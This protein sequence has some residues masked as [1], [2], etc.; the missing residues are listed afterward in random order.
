MNLAS[1]ATVS[2]ARKL[3][4]QALTGNTDHRQRR[5]M[6]GQELQRRNLSDSAVLIA[7]PDDVTAARDRRV[8]QELLNGYQAIERSVQEILQGQIHNMLFGR[9]ASAQQRH[10]T[11]A[12]IECVDCNHAAQR[13]RLNKSSPQNHL[14][15]TWKWGALGCEG[16]CSDAD[17]D[18]ST[19]RREHLPVVPT[20]GVEGAQLATGVNRS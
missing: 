1:S 9:N 5:R 13:E 18:H 2:G 14:Q 6:H 10:V 11:G 15:A 20:C 12:A 3:V 16:V 8:H 7:R 19:G 17:P 4:F